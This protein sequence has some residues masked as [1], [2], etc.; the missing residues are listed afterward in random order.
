MHKIVTAVILAGISTLTQAEV[1]RNA[2]QF[3][4]AVEQGAELIEVNGTIVFESDYQNAGNALPVIEADNTVIRGRN[5]AV[6]KAG[7]TGFRFASIFTRSMVTMSHLRIEGFSTQDNGGAF[8]VGSG[9]LRLE[10]VTLAGNRSQS[11]GG[12]IYARHASV[13]VRDSLLKNNSAQQQGG[14]IYLENGGG[15]GISGSRLIDN[16]ASSGCAVAYENSAG[17]SLFQNLIRG[18]CA[19]AQIEGRNFGANLARNNFVLDSGMAYRFEQ[20]PEDPQDDGVFYANILGHIGGGTD[21]LC[22]FTGTA[23]TNSAGFNLAENASCELEE[24]TDRENISLAETLDLNGIPTPAEGSPALDAIRIPLHTSGNV[25]CSISDATGL[26]RPQDGNGDGVFECDIGA[27]EKQGGPDIGPAMS[28][29]YFDPARNGEGYFIEMLGDNRAWVTFF[30]YTPLAAPVTVP[31]WFFGVGEVVGNSI[32]VDKLYSVANLY[33]G[34]PAFG[35]AYDPDDFNA[36]NVGSLSLVF[37]NCD[38]TA[39]PGRAYFRSNGSPLIHAYGTVFTH[40]ARLT[41]IV[42]CD[43]QAVSA[44]SGLS[45]SFYAPERSGEGITVQWLSEDRVF[46]VFYTFTP[47]RF[48]LWMVSGETAVE[49]NTVTMAMYYPA[50]ST[51]FGVH[52]NEGEVKLEKWGTVTIDYTSCNTMGFTYDSVLEEYGSGQFA[53]QR[54]TQPAG[55]K[56]TIAG[57]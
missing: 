23:T 25:A 50:V 56:C 32:V 5:N 29:A 53:Y 6:I 16:H 14:A 37:S 48:P 8:R 38:A 51:P 57:N 49:G 11:S 28:G 17:V 42:G 2:N 47:E 33:A 27:V 13:N 52:F 55:T 45:G 43:G 20:M 24:A 7:A 9:T 46:A 41:R 54:L 26:G 34:G 21:P 30:S 40:A 18:S 31:N 4:R 35:G 22:A 39:S 1:V 19:G 12:A 36:T 10:N 44:K 15:V 3:I